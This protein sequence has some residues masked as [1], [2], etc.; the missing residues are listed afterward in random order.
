MLATAR[1]EIVQPPTSAEA[2]RVV[3]SL[4]TWALMLS[5]MCSFGA[6]LAVNAVLAAYYLRN[7][8]QL[9]Q[10]GASNWAAMFGFLNFVTRPLGGA[11][12]DLLY[13]STNSLWAKKHW[14]TVCGILG[15]VA[16]V[17]VGRVDYV[18]QP[19]MFGLVALAAIFLEA[20]NGANFALVPHVHP[21]A[22]G[23]VS[24]LTGAAGNLG[25]ILFSVVFRFVTRVNDDVPRNSPMAD[26]D[27]AFW[28][29]GV[30]HIG[31]FMAVSWIPP[32]PKH[33]I[34]GH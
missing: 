4:H 15:G 2:R 34:G 1:G 10:T 7:F 8:P 20:G 18:H 33:Q 22:N 32:I 25:G 28:I 12:A 9:G 21:F 3:L 29:I 23:I 17:V 14:I 24:G 13:K 6:E 26:Y 16:L 19:T 11:V 5:Y 31:V 30:V 27:A